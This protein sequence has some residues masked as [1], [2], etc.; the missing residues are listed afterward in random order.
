M[1]REIVRLNLERRDSVAAL[2]RDR[3]RDEIIVTEQF[4]YPTLEKGP[5]WIIEI[6]ARMVDEGE[7]PADAIVRELLEEVG[8]RARSPR[9]IGSFYLSPGGTSER[10]HLF[11]VEINDSGKQNGGGGV[12]NE[13]EDIQVINYPV[14]DALEDLS[15][16]KI[17]DAKTI[18][19]LQ[20]LAL[21][22][23]SLT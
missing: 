15:Q 13:G 2:V 10:I 22:R 12:A 14:S 6:P 21:N 17:F 11:Y 5:G 7:Y 20:W 1:S 3:A 16:G 4:R 9:P 23:S 8:Y 19:A 18:I